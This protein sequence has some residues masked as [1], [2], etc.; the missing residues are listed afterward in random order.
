LPKNEVTTKHGPPFTNHNVPNRQRLSFFKASSSI[1]IITKFPH[2][3]SYLALYSSRNVDSFVL[4]TH[5][6]DLKFKNPPLLIR[7]W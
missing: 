6:F 1:S 3:T 5:L 4:K 2:L 7:F